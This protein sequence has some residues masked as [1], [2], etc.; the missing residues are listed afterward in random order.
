[1]EYTLAAIHNYHDWGWVQAHPYGDDLG[2]VDEDVTGGIGDIK[3][4]KET[5][6]QACRETSLDVTL[7]TCDFLAH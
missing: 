4:C 1:M 6:S 3:T 2:M 7:V 5:Y